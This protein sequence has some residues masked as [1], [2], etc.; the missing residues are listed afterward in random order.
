MD[1]AKRPLLTRERESADN[2]VRA[3]APVA[4]RLP[5]SHVHSHGFLL[6][7]HSTGPVGRGKATAFL[8][9]ALPGT[10]GVA[11]PPRTGRPSGGAPKGQGTARF[12]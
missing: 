1:T 10:A 3:P 4:L 8:L 7:V 11:Q 5:P 12:S 2:A 6:L 9:L